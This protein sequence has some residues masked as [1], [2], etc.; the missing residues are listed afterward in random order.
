MIA[1]ARHD[2]GTPDVLRE[3]AGQ[4]ALAIQNEDFKKNLFFLGLWLAQ[5]ADMDLAAGDADSAALM[6]G[7]LEGLET[8]G[9]ELDWTHEGRR[10]RVIDG[11]KQTMGEKDFDAAMARGAKLTIDELYQ[12]VAT[13]PEE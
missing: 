3:F 7:G 4:A 11:L 9:F 8:G 12:L 5:R 13:L 10:R 6:V 2:M 1:V